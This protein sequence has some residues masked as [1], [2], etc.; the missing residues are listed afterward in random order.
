MTTD[1]RVSADKD[2]DIRSHSDNGTGP[3]IGKMFGASDVTTFF[4][5]PACDDV[6]SVNGQAVIVGVPHATPYLSVGSYCANAPAAIRKAAAPFSNNQAHMNFDVGEPTLAGPGRGAVDLGD[7]AVSEE[8]PA[9]NRALIEQTIRSIID[10]GGV[11]VVLGGDDSVPI[12]VFAAYADHAP[13]TVVQ[14]DA[15]IDWRDEVDGERYGLSSNMRR[16]SE[17]PHV[18]GMVQIGQ[19]AIGS[20]RPADAAAARAYGATFISARELARL[21]I[22]YALD[23]IPANTN[24]IINL[25]IDGMKPAEVPGVIGRAPGG[26]GYWEVVELIHGIASKSRIAGFNLL[27][28]VPERDVDGLGANIAAHVVLNALAAIHREV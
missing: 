14:V 27:E 4:G 9:D 5:L 23:A 24:I 25:D 1:K 8:N 6:T 10:R 28:F 11:P 15:H 26:L 17:M 22:D 20:A 16:A 2:V 18:A 19:R 13:V 3:D 12:P 21:G 7:L